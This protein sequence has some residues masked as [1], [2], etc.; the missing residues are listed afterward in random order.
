MTNTPK[1]RLTA[2]DMIAIRE[3]SEK[4]VNHLDEFISEMGMIIAE[5]EFDIFENSDDAEDFAFLT[6]MP[7][8]T[9]MIIQTIKREI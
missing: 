5:R 7:A 2:T 8:I 1:I 9:D 6:V 4:L 3:E